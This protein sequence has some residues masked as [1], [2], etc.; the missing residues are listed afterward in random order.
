[1]SKASRLFE[2]KE[3]HNAWS[4]G[5][6]PDH[7]VEANN[8]VTRECVGQLLKSFIDALAFTNNYSFRR[9]VELV[10]W[11]LELPGRMPSR[12]LADMYGLSHEWVQKRARKIRE[13]VNVSDM[14]ILDAYTDAERREINKHNK[15][16]MNKGSKPPIKESPKHPPTSGVA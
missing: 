12:N 2:I 8:F 5:N 1:M 4:I 6:V 3:N 9:H 7:R 15:K 14:L 16:P 10:R 11:A 13:A